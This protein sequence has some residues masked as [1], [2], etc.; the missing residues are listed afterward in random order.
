MKLKS[1]FMAL[2]A[3]AVSFVA[4]ENQEDPNDQP[5]GITV[6]PTELTFE[7]A[8]GSQSVEVTATRNWNAS[9]TAEWVKVSVPSGEASLKPQ[10]VSISVLANTGHDREADVTFSI[11]LAKALV[12][13]VQ[14]GPQGV[15]D[16]GKGTKE[17]PYTV[18]GVVDYV[19]S[20]GADVESPIKV[21]VK[22]KIS[23]VTTT[24]EASGTYGNASFDMVDEDGSTVIFKAFQTYYMGNRK[25]KS[26][27]KDVKAG[28]EVIIF[29]PVVNYKGN[30]PETEGKGASFVYSLNGE[31]NGGD[32]QGQ[33]GD[34]TMA[35]AKGAGT[36]ADPFNVSAAIAKAKEVGQTAS[37]EYYYIKGKVKEVT[38]QFAAQYGNATFTMVDEGYT[39][40]FTAYRIL[41][42][43]NKKWTSG[44]KTLNAGDEVVIC[45]QIVNYKGNTPETN[46]GGAYLYSLNG[47]KGNSGTG[48]EETYAEAKGT[49][50]QADPFNV[51]AAIAKAKEVGET[52]S[53][54]AYYIKGKVGEVTEQFGAQYGNATF[55]MVDEGY[56][57]V[58]TAFRILYFNNVK[59]TEGGKTLNAGDEVVIV[60]KIVN[61]KGNTPETSQNSAYLYSLNGETGGETPPEPQGNP[62]GT[63]TLADPFNADAAVKCV[64]DNGDK[65]TAS[66]YY[67]KGKI[68]SIKYSF[69]AEYGT[70]TFNISDDG[71]TT[72][73]QFTCYSVYYLENQAWVEG[74]T[75][76]AVGDEVI[77]YGKLTVYNGTY[78][79]A[80]KKAYIYSL[81]GKTSDVA[82]PSFGVEK[83]EISVGAPATSATIKVTGNVAWTASSTD[84]TVNPVSGEGAG[85]ITVTFDANTAEQAK[86]YKV[87]V[88]TEA[89]VA[90]KS[91]E[92]VITQAAASSGNATYVEVDFTTENPDLPQASANGIQDG[93]YT[94]GGQTFVL[95]A[96]D[97][98]YQAKSGDAYYLLIGKKDSYIE[99]PT[100]A[101]KALVK[102]E[103][104]TGSGASENVIIDIYKGSEA[105][106]INTAKLKKGT[107]YSWDV[108]GEAG[109]AY[110]IHITNA[111]NAQ[112]Q[113]LK[114]QYE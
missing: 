32:E 59:W 35:E 13:V 38:D 9:T 49:G 95:H 94:L 55:T 88:A 76:I 91:Y 90:T 84:A 107:E 28:D 18:A 3:A 48:G 65:E 53:S 61:Y 74:N 52:A 101:G 47:D 114:L 17:S 39:A 41:Y 57:A 100:I 37:T 108:N 70:A 10:S 63:G 36:E 104:L 87:T 45:A 23:S 30:T 80:S 60:G 82:G 42:F 50:T 33:G 103:F 15:I 11:G 111:Y 62:Q 12:K 78:E 102:V 21:Y 66:D 77:A 89:D 97:K 96:A 92:V 112:F 68:S 20:L 58:F 71:S 31:S 72:A 7:E 26:G 83:T 34:E 105:L 79:T 16:N 5:A 98:F 51:A 22:G 14:K 24:F 44:G 43:G 56:T 4:C 73:T 8:E 86:T 113:N 64:V 19:N 54:D 85:E 75:Q 29:G 2:L 69:S 106:G 27:D 40:V 110:R 25:W 109:V 93:T 1:L 99:L 6:T 46:Q 81:N 67:V